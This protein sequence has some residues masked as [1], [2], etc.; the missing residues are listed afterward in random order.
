MASNKV[1]WYTYIVQCRDSTLYTGIAK[2][3]LKRLSE[4]NDGDGARYTR[5]R[6]PVA[7]VFQEE[8][9]SRS[10]AL[11]REYQLKKLTR[12]EKLQLIRGKEK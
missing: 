7:L 3:L 9:P 6:L 12:T 1:S 4:H 2:D 10:A 5:S 11:K 8:Y